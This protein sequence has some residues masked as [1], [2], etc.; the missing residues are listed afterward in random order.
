MVESGESPGA[1]LGYRFARNRV[2]NVAFCSCSFHH[3]I[4]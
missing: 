1:I 4:V 3:R 2:M